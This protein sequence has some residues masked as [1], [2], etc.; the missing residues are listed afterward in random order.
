MFML[1]RPLVP[2]YTKAS[3]GSISSATS[4][5]SSASSKN[6]SIASQT[7]VRKVQ[8]IYMKLKKNFEIQNK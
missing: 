3:L 7:T 1:D 2:K 5:I 4:G 6:L 8:K